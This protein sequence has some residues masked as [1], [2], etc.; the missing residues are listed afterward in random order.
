MNQR[1]IGLKNVSLLLGFGLVFFII[2]LIFYFFFNNGANYLVVCLVVQ[3]FAT[4]GIRF[5]KCY[6]MQLL[7]FSQLV[8][9]DFPG[10]IFHQ[11]SCKSIL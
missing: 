4:L 10:R 11:R 1:L 7:K 6:V 2:F 5:V 9:L 8:R 3:D